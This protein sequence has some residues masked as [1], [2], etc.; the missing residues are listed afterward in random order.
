M[1]KKS[2]SLYCWIF[3]V[4]C[5]FVQPVRLLDSIMGIMV[6]EFESDKS[7][8]T[9]QLQINTNVNRNSTRCTQSKRTKSVNLSES[10]Q[11]VVVVDD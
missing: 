5:L 1:R 10:H 8:N 11:E 4:V 3:V 9:L 7:D 6:K 2:N